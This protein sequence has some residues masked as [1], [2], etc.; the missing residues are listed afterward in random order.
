MHLQ[1]KRQSN[2]IYERGV[3]G[4]ELEGWQPRIQEEGG[5]IARGVKQTGWR[6]STKRVD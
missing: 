6:L 4:V 1:R 2:H 3:F 5:G